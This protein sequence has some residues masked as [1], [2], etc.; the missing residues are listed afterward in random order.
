MK[1][2][3]GASQKPL[4]ESGIENHV[5]DVQDAL[6]TLERGRAALQRSDNRGPLYSPPEQE[7]RELALRAAF[8]DRVNAS[9]ELSF[10][11]AREAEQ[12]IER[13]DALQA[14]PLARLEPD[15]LARAANLRGFL[16]A[17]TRRYSA[18]DLA[19]QVQAA[20]AGQDRGLRTAWW[21]ALLGRVSDLDTA[22]A[23]AAAPRTRAE[24]ADREQL[25]ALIDQLATGLR[26]PDLDEQRKQQEHR[27]DQAR[28]LR[29][30]ISEVTSPIT[31]GELRQRLVASGTYARL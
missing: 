3:I 27:V 24:I 10:T 25:V 8:D 9:V 29:R 13:I 7:T 12:W 28:E 5:K 16:E 26:D 19:P 2:N 22:A 6:Q 21:H 30:R 1:L 4:P 11:E 20:A 17:D 18:A 31:Q 23:A 14:N 15:D